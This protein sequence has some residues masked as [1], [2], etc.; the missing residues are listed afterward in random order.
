MSAPPTKQE[1]QKCYLARDAH[2]KCLEE[3]ND[4]IYK[5]TITLAEFEKNC[6]KMWVK[7]FERTRERLLLDKLRQ[8]GRAASNS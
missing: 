1:R 8:Q 7:H 2:F 6:P 4:D 3:H 5:C